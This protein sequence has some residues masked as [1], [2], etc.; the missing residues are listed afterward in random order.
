MFIVVEGIDG[1]GKTTFVQMLAE[2]FTRK[3]Y[4]L[5]VT[6]EPGGSK[7]AERIRELILSG[8]GFSPDTELALMMASRLDH[9]INEILPALV[10]GKIVLCDRFLDSSYIY[11]VVNRNADS[12]FY[13]KLKE[14]IDSLVTVDL[15]LL[16]EADLDVVKR[17][18]QKKDKDLIELRFDFEK[19]VEAK[20][21]YRDLANSNHAADHYEI[22]TV[23]DSVPKTQK[24][25]KKWVKAIE[26]DHLYDSVAHL[27]ALHDLI[28][29]PALLL[30]TLK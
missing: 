14:H 1:V 18:M 4:E 7:D 27:D 3:G 8:D 5:L 17:R 29:S 12:L 11:Q 21:A 19:M 23:E 20:N 30:K 6:R 15:T 10:Q 13:R 9:V 26:K 28:T 25:V 2:E 24:L 16:L 22:I